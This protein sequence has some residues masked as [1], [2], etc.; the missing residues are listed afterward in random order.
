VKK[1]LFDQV[2]RR[3]LI[4]NQCWE[5]PSVDHEALNISREDRI[6]TIT[7]AGCNALDYLLRRPESIDCVDMNPF[8]TALLELKLAALQTLGYDRF[9]SMFGYG[10]LRDHRTLYA[11]DLRPRLTEA[12]QAVWD[13]R[14]DYFAWEGSGFYF[15]GTSGFFARMINRYIDSRPRLREDLDEFQGI[16]LMEYQAWFYRTKIAPQLWT[17]PV[18]FFLRRP[19][20]MTMLGVPMEQIRQMQLAGTTDL[21]TII[22]KR[23]EH[24]FTHVPVRDNYFWRVYI[25]GYYTPECCPNYLKPAYFEN[26]KKLASRIRFHTMT[27]TEFLQQSTEQFSAFVLLDH[28]DWLA[29]NPASLQEEWTWILKRAL[30]GARVIYRSG[31]IRFDHIPQAAMRQLTFE[32][33]LTRTLSRRDR[34]GTYGSFYLARVNA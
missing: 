20:V 15:H 18:R 34:V 10:R 6:V 31:G 29:S 25:N 24:M 30:S 8:Q 2:H 27:L 5:D 21:S 9:F 3:N 19:G 13:R 11:R 14:I 23:V 26:L 33:A 22:E 32:H 12:S 16:D 7:S 17:A 28:M 1:W 4:Y